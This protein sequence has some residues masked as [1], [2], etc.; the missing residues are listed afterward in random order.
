MCGSCNTTGHSG[1]R[2]GSSNHFLVAVFVVGLVAIVIASLAGRQHSGAARGAACGELKVASTA[3]ASAV[4][5]HLRAGT[6]PLVADTD[7]FVRRVRRDGGDQCA[8][9]LAFARRS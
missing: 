1:A 4:T 9:V 2:R 5:R 3:Y 8:G 7:A 6:A